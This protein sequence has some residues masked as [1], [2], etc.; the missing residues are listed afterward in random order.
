MTKEPLEQSL[1]VHIQKITEQLHQQRLQAQN[2]IQEAQQRQKEYHD[3]CI[4]TIEFKIGDQ[5]LLYEFAKEKVHGDKL[6]EKWKGPYFIH[7]YGPLRIYKIRT[8]DRKILKKLINTD[9]LK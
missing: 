2:N 4:R 6:R 9:R 5:V 8:K 3:H 1:D 7:N